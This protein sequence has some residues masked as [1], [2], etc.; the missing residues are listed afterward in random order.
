MATDDNDR[1]YMSIALKEA[2]KALKTGDVPVGA[3]IVC[4]GIVVAGARNTKEK[5]KVATRHAEINAIEKAAKKLSKWRLND[6][7]IYVTMEPCPM[8]A[9]A[10]HQARISRI[11][12]GARDLKHG[13]CGTMTN[14]FELSGLNHYP[15]VVGG[16]L[17]GECAAVLKKFFKELRLRKRS[18]PEMNEADC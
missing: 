7:T 2:I 18:N 1:K 3:V 14:L 15:E 11:V 16:V 13:A 6:C 12:F 8:C 10:L 5:S 4:N 9:G 17:E